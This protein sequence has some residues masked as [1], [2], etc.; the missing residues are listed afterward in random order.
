M[1]APTIELVF[2]LSLAEIKAAVSLNEFM[3]G[4]SPV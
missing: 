3:Y 1:K 2:L 4:I